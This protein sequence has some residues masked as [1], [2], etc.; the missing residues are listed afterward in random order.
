M[1]T[2]EDDIDGWLLRLRNRLVK[3]STRTAD[4]R[5]SVEDVVAKDVLDG[6]VEDLDDIIEDLDADLEDDDEDD[7]DGEDDDGEDDDVE[8]EEEDEDEDIET[9]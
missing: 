8:A 6:Y 5:D 9:A 3:H 4:L 1:N 2:S 7:D